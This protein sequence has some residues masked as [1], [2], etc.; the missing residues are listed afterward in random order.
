MLIYILTKEK[1]EVFFDF[2]GKSSIE[3]KSW[4]AGRHTVLAPIE[5]RTRPNHVS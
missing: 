2:F 3:K 4:N 1:K 5:P